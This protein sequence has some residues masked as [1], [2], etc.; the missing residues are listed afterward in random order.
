MGRN[1]SLQLR[2]PM[3]FLPPSMQ[4]V[5]I[6]TQHHRRRGRCS[7]AGQAA[8]LC[9]R[10]RMAAR[11]TGC[12]LLT[13]MTQILRCSGWMRQGVS[14]RCCDSGGED[15]LAHVLANGTKVQGRSGRYSV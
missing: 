5:A 11:S 2:L 7:R 12:I 15:G 13:T 4:T 3:R 9:G 8:L 6:S 10:R 1:N 14:C